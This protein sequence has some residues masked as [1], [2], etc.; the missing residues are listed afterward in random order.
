MLKLNSL[1][2]AVAVV[3]FA[4][5]CCEKTIKV[6]CVGDSI[7]EGMA[8]EWQSEN[9]YPPQLDNMLS[10]EY[11]V[12]NLGRSSTTM[13]RKG[14]FPYWTAK[15]YTDIFRYHPDIVIIKLGTNDAKLFQW[16]KDEYK[17]S[18]QA[19]IDTLKTIDTNPR[20]IL[21][22]PVPPQ[23]TRWEIT[24][25]VVGGEVRPLVK[26]IAAENNLELIDL[27][28]VVGTNPELFARDGIHP[29]AEGAK[30]IANAIANHLKANP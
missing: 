15:E 6:A 11:E 16:N 19:M 26:Q 25:S 9:A 3:A 29:N 23:V 8:I 1:A 24:D 4:T 27:Y 18:Y 14:D 17:S 10:S 5:S 22:T 21:C 12:M 13:M 30:V 28:E 7:T 20:I 2:C